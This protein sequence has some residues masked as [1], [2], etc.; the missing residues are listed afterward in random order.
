M[1]CATRKFGF[2]LLIPLAVGGI[3]VAVCSSATQA[4]TSHP[5]PVIGVI[6]GVAFESDQYYVHG[7]ACQEGQ[8]GSID[9]HI[10]ANGPAGGK[11]PG[12]FVTGGPANLSNEP[13][14]DRECHDANGGLHRFRIPLPN[15]LLRTFQNQTLYAHG[16]AVA[17]NVENALIAGSGN[18][19]LSAPKWAPDPPTPTSSMILPGGLR[20]QE[21]FL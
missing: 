1:S 18:F 21:R 14:V 7:W 15:Q 2:W 8:R 4:Q 19:K 17:G 9:V 3:D 16:I 13:A 11:P 20:H 12:T 5:G 6:D 10:Y